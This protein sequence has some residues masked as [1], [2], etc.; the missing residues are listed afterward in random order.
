MALPSMSRVSRAAM[1]CCTCTAVCRSAAL[2]GAARARLAAAAAA[3]A[4]ISRYVGSHMRRSSTS[5]VRG[6]LAPLSSSAR[7]RSAKM[8]PDQLD[9]DRR[10]SIASR[11]VTSG[12]SAMRMLVAGPRCRLAHA[13]T[14]T[15]CT[16]V[17]YLRIFPASYLRRGAPGRE[18]GARRAARAPAPA[19]NRSIQDCAIACALR[20]RT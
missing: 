14:Q 8:T 20:R 12:A 10:P 11:R 2:A 13:L 9:D 17:V 5:Y 15:P 16:A 1:S 18:R 6:R 4:A 3:R 7:T 19:P